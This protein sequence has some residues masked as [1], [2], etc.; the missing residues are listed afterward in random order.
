MKRTE[1]LFLIIINLLISISTVESNKILIGIKQKSVNA[2]NNC[3]YQYNEDVESITASCKDY[4]GLMMDNY[5]LD[6]NSVPIAPAYQ[7]PSLPKSKQQ[8]LSM[9]LYVGSALTEPQCNFTLQKIVNEEACCSGYEN[10]PYCNTSVCYKDQGGCSNGGVCESPNLCSCPTNYSGLQCDEDNPIVIESKHPLQLYCYQSDQC[11]SFKKKGYVG[12]AVSYDE[13]CADKTGSWGSQSGQCVSCNAQF[14]MGTGKT[15]QNFTTC[16]SYGLDFFRTFDD[17]LYTYQGRCKY[18]LTTPS[19]SSSSS[20]SINVV[21]E[22]CASDSG[23]VKRVLINS[24]DAI[25]KSSDDGLFYQADSS[26][27]LTPLS[28]QNT[29]SAITV[30]GTSMYVLRQDDFVLLALEAGN[31]KVKWDNHT[32]IIISA[33]NSIFNG[34]LKGLCGNADSDAGNEFENFDNIASFG[35]SFKGAGR[36]DIANTISTC[37]PDDQT[38]ANQQCGKIRLKFPGCSDLVNSDKYFSMCVQNICSRSQNSNTTLDIPSVMDTVCTHLSAYS[39]ICSERGSCIQWRSDTLCETKCPGNKVWSDCASECPT[40]CRNLFQIP[41]A[42]CRASKIGRCI[43]GPGEVEYG[44]SCIKPEACPCLY[45]G[46]E[47]PPGTVRQFDCNTCT[48][49]SSL[50]YCTEKVCPSTCEIMG[51]QF[52]TFDGAKFA[53]NDAGCQYVVVEPAPNNSDERANVVVSVQSNTEDIFSSDSS[54]VFI[55]KP[56]IINIK[57]NGS[58]IILKA[59][60]P[61]LGDS[62]T[63]IFVD[64]E[65][66]TTKQLYKIS[67]KNIYVRKLTNIYTEVSIG[68]H[69][70]LYFDGSKTLYIKA[71]DVLKNNV[72]GLCGKFDGNSEN[73]FTEKKTIFENQ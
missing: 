65:D 3:I 54:D 63:N 31:V 27:P 47:H 56:K 41:S 17:Q 69:F 9:Q 45:D 23:C 19:D 48:C 11:F 35:N 6:E 25:I 4:I 33:H 67:D 26:K 22:N 53:F 34:D 52:N 46:K 62:P 20:W 42:Y 57:V 58:E 29:D 70:K 16:H 21:Y 10:Y 13:C 14:H 55:N 43:C 40:T 64:G 5:N 28:I 8:A 72:I 1:I 30:P 73:D 15:E 60:T 38:L 51:T 39:G 61:G 32:N 2:P 7:D 49:N 24:G 50:W 66:H 18:I 12:Q 71:S 59:T 37:K 68:S 36:P 44:N